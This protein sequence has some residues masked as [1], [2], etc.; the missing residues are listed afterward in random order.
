MSPR[1]VDFDAAR[2]ERRRDPVTLRIGGEAMILSA[3]VPASVALD[4][5]RLKADEGEAFVVP[6]EELQSI[7]QRLF[8]EDNWARILDRHRL[9]LDEL[10]DL[11]KMTVDALQTRDDGPPNR[12]K[13]RSAG[14]RASAGSKTGT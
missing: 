3:G 2:A 6:Y 14:R 5:I 4:L 9:D 11:I 13:R 1:V 8:G 7:G 12:A 10:G